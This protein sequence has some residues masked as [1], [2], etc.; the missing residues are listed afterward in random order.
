MEEWEVVGKKDGHTSWSI[1]GMEAIAI[2][3]ETE[4]NT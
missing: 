2:C 1:N 4:N 3:V